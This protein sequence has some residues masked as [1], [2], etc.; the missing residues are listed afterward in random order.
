MNKKQFFA[1]L[2]DV[3]CRLGSTND[4]GIGVIA[5]RAIPKG[6][7][8]FKNCDPHGGFIEIP[9]AELNAYPCDEAVKNIVRDFCALQEGIYYVPDYGIDALDKSYYLNHSHTPNLE[10]P[11][12]GEPFIAARDIAPGEELTAD[13]DTYNEPSEARRFER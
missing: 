5:I 10:T 4:R 11:D 13:Y 6:T 2:G 12:L 9:E 7:N 1:S 8:P 3:Y